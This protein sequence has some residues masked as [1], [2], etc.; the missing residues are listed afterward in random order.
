MS[1]AA[2]M[3]NRLREAYH[4][5]EFLAFSVDPT[6]RS[7]LAEVAK[8]NSWPDTTVQEGGISAAIQLMVTAPSP[9]R[10]IVDLG[11][12][13]DPVT[14]VQML[15]DTCSADTLI[16]ALG[17]VNDIRLYRD[18]CRAGAADYVV[19]PVV[20]DILVDAMDRALRAQESSGDPARGEAKLG[21][22]VLFIGAKGGIGASTLA[23]NC[24]WLIAHEHRAKTALVDLDLHFGTTAL[25]LDLEPGHGLCEALANPNRI[26]ALFLT[27]AM[28]AES[29]N[30]MLLASEESLDRTT[31][32][33][34]EAATLLFDHLRQNFAFVV[35]DLPRAQL[36]ASRDLLGKATDIVVVC[37]L[38]LVSVRDTLRVLSFVRDNSPVGKISV[39]ANRVANGK[40]Q[41]SKSDFE[42]GIEARIDFLVPDEPKTAA[43]AAN[44]GKPLPTVAKRGGAVNALRKLAEGLAG[45]VKTSAPFWRRF[46]S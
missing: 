43:L 38:S 14:A 11:E 23:T 1:S 8:L 39:V 45:P 31:T 34:P 18:V 36:S 15:R 6:T 29:S 28:V 32:I 33:N 7:V 21:R 22:L 16:I 46:F 3:L 40:G 41:I 12:T 19:K 20:K 25:D 37:D 30:F 5:D 24:A 13:P 42:R 27:S 44:S 2:A 26:D 17:A 4:N 35:A 9:R 10:L